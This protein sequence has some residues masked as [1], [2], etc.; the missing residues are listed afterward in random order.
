[1]NAGSYAAIA[2]VNDGNYSGSASGT[3]TVSKAAATVTLGSLT[4]T[5]TGTARTATAT[6]VPGGLAVN[7][8]YDGAAAAPVNHG[9]YA[10]SA[11]V[12][13]ANYAASISGVLNITGI[14][15]FEWRALHF[16]PAEIAAGFADDTVDDDFDGL[17]NLSEYGLGTDPRVFTPQPVFAFD[18]SA[19]TLS[20]SRPK[21]LP[22]VTYI[23]ESSGNLVTWTPLSIELI[24][25]GPTQTL[26]ARSLIIPGETPQSFLRLRFTR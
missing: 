22:D 6:T 12:N 16:T 8:T 10:V 15:I 24:T 14:P 20:F 1:V 5:Y 9:S 19:L 17:T 3:L 21:G 2:T 25:D 11:V 23:A 18:G 13:D 4:Q 7:I 26:R